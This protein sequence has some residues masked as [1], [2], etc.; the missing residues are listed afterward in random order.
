MLIKQ[1]KF[2]LACLL[3]MFETLLLQLHLIEC[4]KYIYSWGS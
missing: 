3:V 1:G 2:V 4:K